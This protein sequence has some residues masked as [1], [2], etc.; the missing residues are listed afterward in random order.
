MTKG[1]ASAKRMKIA[2]KE[3]DSTP[4]N[5]VTYGFT[6]YFLSQ[7]FGFILVMQYYLS[8]RLNTC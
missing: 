6:D 7:L 4:I 8:M 1:G 3:T 5:N 2:A